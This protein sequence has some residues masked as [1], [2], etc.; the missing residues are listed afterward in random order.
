MRTYCCSIPTCYRSSQCLIAETKCVLQTRLQQWFDESARIRHTRTA[1]EIKRSIDQGH[2]SVCSQGQCCV[3]SRT[4]L[5]RH[6]DGFTTHLNNQRFGNGPELFRRGHTEW[7]VGQ[8]GNVNAGTGE[9]HHRVHSQWHSTARSDRCKD[10]NAMGTRRM[11]PELTLT[12][13]ARLRQTMYQASEHIIRDR[14][15]HQLSGGNRSW[16]IGDRHSRKQCLRAQRRDLGDGCDR[17]NPMSSTGEGSAEDSTHSTSTDDADPKTRRRTS[18]HVESV[19][20]GSVPVVRSPSLPRWDQAWELSAFGP[21]GFYRREQPQEHFRTAVTSGRVVAQ[22]VSNYLDALLQQYDVVQ[23]DD[24]GAGSGQLL[25]DLLAWA[26]ARDMASRVSLRGFDLRP[27]P[28]HLDQRIN[29]ITG[30]LRTTL[31]H[32]APITGVA[33]AHE[34]LDDLPCPILELDGDGRPHLLLAEEG[35]PVLGAVLDT[36]QDHESRQHM[37]AEIDPELL[38]SWYRWAATWWP[39]ERPWMRCEVG[40]SRDLLWTTIVE[41]V[42]SG[43]ALAIDYGHLRSERSAGTW[44]GGSCIGY[45]RG[46]AVA[47]RADGLR[48]LTAHVA[49]DSLAAATPQGGRLQQLP[50]STSVPPGMYL[51]AAD[52]RVPNR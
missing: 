28:A 45:R 46:R 15:D 40:L 7:T 34:L 9:G 25:E 52:C 35:E 24:L 19:E 12:Y 38:Y 5:L 21:S 29:W 11:A 42:Q 41:H 8:A 1:Q 6:P 43:W 18:R 51:L 16:D 32:L 33:L 30:D 17:D 22:L 2:E 14:N 49:M 44:D 47:P 50:V 10:F 26:T 3:V 36:R 4:C 23:V 27:R 48:N 20:V 39:L 13:A 31:P 37:T